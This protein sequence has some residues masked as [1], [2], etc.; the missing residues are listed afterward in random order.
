MTLPLDPETLE[1][2]YEYLRTT[3]PFNRWNLPDGEDV[4][5]KVVRDP[6]LRGWYDVRGGKHTIAISSRCIGHSVNLIA[7]MAH[8]M[9]HLHQRDVKIETSGTQHNAAFNALADRVCRHHGFDPKLF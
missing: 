8:E 7:T 5:F 3:P 1:A 2:A 4:S 9:I 6:A